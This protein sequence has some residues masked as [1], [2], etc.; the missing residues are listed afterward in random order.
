MTTF[1]NDVISIVIPIYN[2]EQYIKNSLLSVIQQTYKSL[3]IILVND[4]SK[5]NSVSIAVDFLKQNSINFHLISQENKGLSEARNVGIQKCT[6][7][8]IICLDADDYLC[9]SALEEMINFAIESNQDC[10]FCGFK[11][12]SLSHI[13]DKQTF[14]NGNKVLKTTNALNDFLNRKIKLLVP[15]M[16]CKKT[17]YQHLK[18]DT[19]C[20]YD[21]DIHFLWRLLFSIDEIGIIDSD[22]YNY[23]TRSDSMVHTLSLES[24]HKTL[25]SYIRVFCDEYDF[26]T[27]EYSFA[28]VGKY[29]LGATHVLSKCHRYCDIKTSFKNKDFLPYITCAQKRGNLK[30]K[31]IGFL[32]KRFPRF[33]YFINKRF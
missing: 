12:V 33:Y 27:S 16:L 22:F 14:N 7:E 8:W 18:F 11:S 29:I 28:I 31:M 23:L 25:K 20:S 32:F 13:F 6:G 3:E 21:E 30:L 9:P 19:E 10:V 17:I 5:D 15:G 24:F 1:I 26:K 2:V 4:G